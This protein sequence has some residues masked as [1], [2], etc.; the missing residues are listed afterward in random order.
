MTE[1]HAEEPTG[2]RPE[3]PKAV[4]P[5]GSVAPPGAKAIPEQAGFYF[6]WQKFEVDLAMNRSIFFFVGEAVFV[7]G[8]AQLK[9]AQEI[10]LFPM[11]VLALLGLFVS[12]YWVLASWVQRR[13]TTTPIRN[14]LQGKYKHELWYEIHEKRGTFKLQY[15]H[16]VLPILFI[17]F[18]IAIICYEVCNGQGWLLPPAGTS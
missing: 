15:M 17:S 10:Y 13:D 18:W 3:K 4:K 12:I 6:E 14:M 5:S 2:D 11:F 16:V 9:T 7:T 1:T 8:Y